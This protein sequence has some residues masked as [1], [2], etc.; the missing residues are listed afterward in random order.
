[1]AD[2]SNAL[3]ISSQNGHT[4]TVEFLLRDLQVEV[5]V[6]RDTGAT[7]FLIACEEGHA[8]VARLLAE[9]GADINY[10]NKA[11]ATPFYVSCQNGRKYFRC[12]NSCAHLFV[13]SLQNVTLW[14]CYACS[15]Q[16]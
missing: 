14:T 6:P 3:Y 11:G 1:M 13:G 15:A 10:A 12:A 8:E 16:T 7:A 2:G 5:D 4:A 9:Y